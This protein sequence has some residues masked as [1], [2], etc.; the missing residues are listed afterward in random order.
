MKL[1]G[2]ERNA[3]GLFVQL[4]LRTEKRLKPS[5][6]KVVINFSLN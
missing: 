4:N 3:S 1:S 6:N 5:L 2:F